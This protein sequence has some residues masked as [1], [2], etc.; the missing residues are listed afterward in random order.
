[1]T[2]KEELKKLG[3]KDNKSSGKFVMID[4]FIPDEE[5]KKKKEDENDKK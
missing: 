2:K 3:I 5:D 4:D 1:M